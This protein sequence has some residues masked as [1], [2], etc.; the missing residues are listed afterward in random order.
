MLNPPENI[1][2]PNTELYKEIEKLFQGMEMKYSYED[3]D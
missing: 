1:G 3:N 2:Y